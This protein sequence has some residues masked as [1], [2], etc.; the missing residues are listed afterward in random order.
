MARAGYVARGVVY[1]IVG[2]FAVLAALSSGGGTTGGIGAL[3]SL[4]TQP[5]GSVLLAAVA[6]GLLCFSLWRLMQALLDADH[7]GS[8]AKALV[9]RTGFALSAAV[10][11]ALAFSAVALLLGL[12]AGA[13]DGEGSA[14]DWT[15]RLLSAPFG[16]WLVG[17]I[18]LA[19]AGTGIGVAVKAWKATFEER[20]S[21]DEQTRRWVTPM[22]RWGFFARA[23]VFLIVGGFLVLAAV[24]ANPSEAKS[25]AGA[26][27]T[28]QEQPY[29]WIVLG[30]TALGLFAFGAFQFV[31][32]YY[33]RIDA[34]DPGE[35]GREAQ[36][37]V[38]AA[39]HALTR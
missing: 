31:V 33:R 6:L 16:Q 18:G 34:P 22:G 28:L 13:G 15:A 36:A 25:L 1:M 32:A 4:L 21:L 9:R 24:H 26:L 7:L 37:K 11:A 29:G 8:G 5:F 35:V 30:I 39:T 27:R 3:H 20:L 12:S 10:N 14:K 19:V 23:V 2:G 38:K 17:A